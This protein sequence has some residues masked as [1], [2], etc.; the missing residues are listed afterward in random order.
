MTSQY[1]PFCKPVKYQNLLLSFLATVP[2]CRS[3]LNSHSVQHIVSVVLLR[4]CCSHVCAL[5]KQQS[6]KL[7]SPPTVS[8]VKFHFTIF[9]SGA[10]KD[11]S[12]F[13]RQLQPDEQSS[14]RV[15]QHSARE[16]AFKE[17]FS[18]P[19]FCRNFI[20]LRGRERSWV[21]TLFLKSGYVNVSGVRNFGLIPDAVQLFNQVF[22]TQAVWEHAVVDNSTSSG[23]LRCCV[24][25]TDVSPLTATNRAPRRQRRGKTDS[26]GGVRKRRRAVI[27]APSLNLPKIQQYLQRNPANGGGRGEI[28]LTLRP[29]FFPGAVIHL[30]LLTPPETR[31][32]QSTTAILFAT[33]KYIIVGARCQAD[34]LESQRVLCKVAAQCLY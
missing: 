31:T 26:A 18:H 15:G 30:P 32:N 34:I 22:D 2:A 12:D 20:I 33:K 8:N 3:F 5:M 23:I 17:H 11:I 9:P 13:L 29:F 6:C 25:A 28:H 14:P 1:L 7:C 19:S 10:E 4:S 24:P 21:Y 27:T 16:A